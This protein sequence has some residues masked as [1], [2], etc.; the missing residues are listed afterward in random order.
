MDQESFFQRGKSNNKYWFGI[1]INLLFIVFEVIC[2]V[3]AGSLALVTDA[4]HNLGDVLG[5]VIAFV[6]VILIKRKPT[7]HHTY[8]FY[9]TTILAAFTNSLILVA[10]LAIVIWEAFLRLMNPEDHVDGWIVV[11]VALTGVA[12]N[13]LTAYIF[14]RGSKRDLNE[15]ANYWHFFADALISLCVVFAGFIINFTNWVI[16]DP[17]VSIFA[18]VFILFESWRVLCHA[19]SLVTNGVPDNISENEVEKYLLSFP[20]IEKINDV[21]IWALSTTEVAISAHLQCN[22][23]ADYMKILDDATDGLR[24]KFDIDH[25]TLQLETSDK[26]HRESKI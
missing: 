8:G 9:N 7:K 4:I 22:R 10:S 3:F 17:L 23:P 12:I 26:K 21:H 2:G 25:V 11:I 1:S 6:A 24:K 15:K 13:G 19:F 14:H 18:A 16:L 20:E 5:L